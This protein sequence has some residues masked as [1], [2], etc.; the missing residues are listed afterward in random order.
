MRQRSEEWRQESKGWKQGIEE[1]QRGSKGGRRGSKGWQQGSEGR[2]GRGGILLSVS[3]G[4]N[5][6]GGEIMHR[7]SSLS[8]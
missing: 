6:V 1:W 3:G 5:G 4:W 7:S 8:C 2:D